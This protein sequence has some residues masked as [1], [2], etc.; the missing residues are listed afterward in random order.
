MLGDAHNREVG[1]LV[2]ALG[3]GEVVRWNPEDAASYPLPV[4]ARRVDVV[5]D[6]LGSAEHRREAAAIV[7]APAML[8]LSGPDAVVAALEEL[9]R[10]VLDAASPW[11]T[12]ELLVASA[13][14][15]AS[16]SLAPLQSG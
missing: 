6:V 9:L 16:P 8:A 3:V 11:I 7:L 5:L 12:E 13:Q 10:G 4:L 1:D 14:R 15:L 2:S